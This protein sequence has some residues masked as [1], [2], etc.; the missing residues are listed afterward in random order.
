MHPM[1]ALH[2][3]GS[4]SLASKLALYFCL[5]VTINATKRA[6][7]KQLI[8]TTIP[9]ILLDKYTSKMKAQWLGAAMPIN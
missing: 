6:N 3:H 1:L 5:N 8:L 7:T 9:S 2:S 4:Y